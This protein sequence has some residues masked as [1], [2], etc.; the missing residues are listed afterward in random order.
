MNPIKNILQTATVVSLSGLMISCGPG[1]ETNASLGSALGGNQSQSSGGQVTP[2]PSP[3]QSEFDKLDLSSQIDGGIYDGYQVTAIDKVKNLLI[4]RLPIPGNLPIEMSLP[5]PQQKDILVEAITE[6]GHSYLQV[7]IPLKYITRGITTVPAQRLP[8]G[9]PLPKMPSG[10]LP[11]LGLAFPGKAATKLYIGVNAVGLY[12]ET[13]FNPYLA[14]SLPI[15]NQAGTQIWGY[16]SL[17]P[18]KASYQG[19]FFLSFQLPNSV[20]KIIDDHLSGIIR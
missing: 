7:S 17:V 12:I 11:S 16:F 15:K 8:N 5:F 9:D 10:E 1:F 4:L 20:A 13:S 18:E 2:V 3:I 6:G 14:L 19:G